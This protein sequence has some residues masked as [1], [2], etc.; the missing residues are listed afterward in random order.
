MSIKKYQTVADYAADGYPTNESRVAQIIETGEVKIDGVNVMTKTPVL[1]DAVYGKGDKYYFFKGGDALNHSALT[2]A[3][4]TGLGQVI[5]YKNGKAIF[6]DKTMASAQ[7]LSV[8]Q[9]AIT[10]IS[11]TTITIGLWMKG[12]YTTR[13]DTEV[14]LSSA[15]LDA[16]S[17]EEI[18]EALNESGNTGQIGY[19]NHGYWAYYDADNSRIVVQCD[20]CADYRQYRCYGSG[21]T[22]SLCVWEDMPVSSVLWRNKMKSTYYGG[23]NFPQFKTYYSVS[24]YT[25]TTDEPIS[26]DNIVNQT[27]FTSSEYC[28][29][30]R[31]K[32]A[33]YDDYLK[34]NMVLFNQKYG[35]FSLPDG[36]ALSKKYG[37]KITQKKDGSIVYKYPALHFVQTIN[38]NITG[39]SAGDLFLPGVDDGMI[40]MD[41]ANMAVINATRTKMG[42][43]AISNKSH[44][45][46]AQRYGACYAWWFGGGGG[47]LYGNDVS[48]SF[49]VQ[50]AALLD[51]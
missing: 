48:A 26:S 7:Y 29:T 11:S 22:I 47:V 16:T 27:A 33:S 39:L 51:I 21:C 32:Y 31:S 50:G 38:Y 8:W 24:G 12:D 2:N 49:L 3:G 42:H 28:A 41:D 1:G 40:F 6:L 23:M 37:N 5:G 18:T 34:A 45:W 30:L 36:L 46:F 19:A 43:N 35:V 44:R 13:K 10:A 9:Y 4:Y 15:T 17:A 14:T 20:F 25:P